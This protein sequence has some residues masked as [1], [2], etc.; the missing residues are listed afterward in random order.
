MTPLPKDLLIK[1]LQQEVRALEGKSQGHLSSDAS[2]P[3]LTFLKHHFPEQQVPTGVI[4]EFISRQPADAAA[5]IAFMSLMLSRLLADKTYCAWV[6][7]EADIFPHG[8]LSYGIRP[9]KIIFIQVKTQQEAFW[10]LEEA[11]KC[12]SLAAVIGDVS[13]YTF[14]QSRRLQLA[15]EE[16]KVTSLIH[17][18][19]PRLLQ[20]TTSA[21][22]WQ[23]RAVPS[24]TTDELP[25]VGFARWQLQL[26]RVKNGKPGS[27]IVAWGAEGL[28]LPERFIPYT[29]NHRLSNIG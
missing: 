20:P 3:E 22:R 15:I 5:T 19:N 10:A 11:V 13:N 29:T 27:W 12:A 6:T 7:M 14:H 18:H 4:H 26:Q 8:L 28:Y 24:H 23:I 1:N 25:G 17:V 21:A 9:D 2:F 16:S